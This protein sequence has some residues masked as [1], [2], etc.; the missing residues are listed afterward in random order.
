MGFPIRKSTDQG[1]F[2]TPRSLSQLITSF[3]ANESQGIHHAPLFT[4][5]ITFVLLWYFPFNM[6]KNFSALLRIIVKNNGNDP[7][8]SQF[9]I[10]RSSFELILT[11][12]FSNNVSIDIC[13]VENI[14][15]EPMTSCVQGR[16]SSQL[17]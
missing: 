15:V 9:K 7:F 14:G 1:L 3:F 12:K 16:R 6:S 5:L 10:E 13:F 11:L 2:A 4:F 8:P 17:S